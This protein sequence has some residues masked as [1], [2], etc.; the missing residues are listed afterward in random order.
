MASQN[1]PASSEYD[2]GGSNNDCTIEG[3][4]Q[5]DDVVGIG[6]GDWGD[7]NGCVSSVSRWW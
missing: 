1:S 2:V 5:Y 4:Q 6:V 3:I 7:W